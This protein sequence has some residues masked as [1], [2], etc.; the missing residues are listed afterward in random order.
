MDE[1]GLT[2]DHRIRALSELTDLLAH[3]S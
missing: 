3:E 1:L 2:P